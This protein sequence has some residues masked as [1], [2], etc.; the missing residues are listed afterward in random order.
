MMEFIRE[1]IGERWI[2][3]WLGGCISQSIQNDLRISQGEVLSVTLFLVET[4]G[5]LGELGNEVD[6][7]LNN[8][9][10]NYEENER[11]IKPTRVYLRR[12]EQRYG[13]TKGATATPMVG[14]QQYS[15]MTQKNAHGMTREN[16]TSYN[17]KKTTVITRNPT[18]MDQRVQK[19]K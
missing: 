10:Q 4:N 11:T 3:V 9:D 16:N 5:I 12:L 13:R 6:G 8:E 2:K 18:L 1:L 19:G 17:T 7:S 14:K 15:D